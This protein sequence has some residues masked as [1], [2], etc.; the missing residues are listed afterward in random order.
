MTL[1]KSDQ[2]RG[3]C[4]EFNCTKHAT[5]GVVQQGATGRYC[6]VMWLCD[7][8]GRKLYGLGPDV[9]IKPAEELR[10]EI[11]AKNSVHGWP[12]F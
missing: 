1:I 2:A 8:C 5:L 9:K 7:A 4:D 3:E 11:R 10:Q 12:D 6:E